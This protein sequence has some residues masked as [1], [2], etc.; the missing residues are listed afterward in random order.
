MAS[1]S[2]RVRGAQRAGEP[3]S[4]LARHSGRVEAGGGD[5]SATVDSP[6]ARG[7]SAVTPLIRVAG[8]EIAW[9]ALA[10]TCTFERLPVAMLWID[11]TL[12]GL[13]AGLQA[14]V[15][16][17]RFGLALQS[18]GRKSVDADWQVIDSAADFASGFAAIARQ[19]PRVD[20]GT[21]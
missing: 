21:R 1:R 12:A 10:G 15:G 2:K 4:P 14:M 18:E 17:E 11:T 13:M 8:I 19:C 7:A 5:S 16:A 9:D 6:Q 20:R 3:D